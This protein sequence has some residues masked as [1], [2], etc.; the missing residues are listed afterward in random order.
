MLLLVIFLLIILIRV[1]CIE[2]VFHY[3]STD[4]VQAAIEFTQVYIQVI[5]LRYTQAAAHRHTP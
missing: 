2:Y 5:D 3:L 4:Y 1:L